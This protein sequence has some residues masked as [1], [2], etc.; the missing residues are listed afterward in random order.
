MRKK[1]LPPDHRYDNDRYDAWLCYESYLKKHKRIATG[2]Q[3]RFMPDPAEI[4]ERIMIMRAFEA[5][6][7][8]RKAI[9]SIMIEDCPPP[10]IVFQMIERWGE[11]RTRVRINRFLR[12]K[13]GEHR[14]K[15]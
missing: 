9:D 11:K 6:N 14:T 15:D 2:H 8:S 12:E 4:Q 3:N 5:I 13:P 1:E 10:H 7:L